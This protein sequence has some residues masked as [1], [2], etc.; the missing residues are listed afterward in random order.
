MEYNNSLNE[1]INMDDNSFQLSYETSQ[2][3][4]IYVSMVADSNNNMMNKCVTIEHPT[5]SSSHILIKYPISDSS[6]VDD[7]VINI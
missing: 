1:D 5:W 7:V 6:C 3:Q 2:E 4:A